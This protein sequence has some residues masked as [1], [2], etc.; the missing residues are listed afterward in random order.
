MDN[1]TR[2]PSKINFH[3]S[4]LLATHEKDDYTGN[5]H[6]S[7]EK[8]F[9]PNIQI[10]FKERFSLKPIDDKANIHTVGKFSLSHCMLVDPS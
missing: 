2:H 7:L 4:W 6:I 10:S 9:R 3:E 1:R 5:I 8:F